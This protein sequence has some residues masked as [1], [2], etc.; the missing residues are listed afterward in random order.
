MS[1]SRPPELHRVILLVEDDPNDILLI[2][3]AF[4]KATLTTVL[5]VVKDGDEAIAYLSGEGPYRNRRR[6]PLPVLILLDL[7]L[8]RRSG[9]EVLQWLKARSGLR[10]I[11]VVVL[12]SSRDSPDVNRAYDLGANSYLV[13]PVKAAELEEMVRTMS[14]YWLIFNHPP[15]C[16]E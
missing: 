15:Q 6:Y 1:A 5:R 16:H 3:R 14:L 2:Q 10:R 8:P 4:R 12:T 7:K 13:K 11:P 9:F